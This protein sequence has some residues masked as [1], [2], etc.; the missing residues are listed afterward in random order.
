MGKWKVIA[1]AIVAVLALSMFSGYIFYIIAGGMRFS[2]SLTGLEYYPSVEVVAERTVAPSEG[3]ETSKAEGGVIEA[4]Q[5]LT[6]YTGQE[7]LISYTASISL[8]VPRGGIEESVDKVMSIV[9]ACNGYVSSMNVGK[10]VAR[11]TVKI[12]QDSFFRFIDEVSEIGKV[13]SRSVSGTD[14]TEKIIDLRARIKNARAVEASLL[15][16]LDRARNVSEVLEV[17]RELSKVREEIE[18]M[19]AQL[20]NLE[21]SVSYSAVTIEISEEEVRR[22]YL[23]L[24]FRVLD[25]RNTLVPNTYIYVKGSRAERLVTDEFGEAKAFFE[26]NTNITLIALF[27]RSDGEVLKAS[28][29][30]TADSNKTV[31]IRF[32]KPSEPPSINLEKLPAIASSLINYLT[33]G[34][35]VIVILIVPLLIIVLILF[36]AVRRIYLRVK[37]SKPA[38]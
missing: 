31:T 30:D 4:P 12:P 37:P 32:D 15:E 16:L 33:T 19:E 1:I 2:P 34:L 23:E 38:T 5:K 36:V 27:Y 21:M 3:V 24:L 17:M 18:V 25:S 14:L 11:L 28:M 8:L 22:E 20:R 26:K 6:A 29:M 10:G 9:G 7:R 35:T 13:V